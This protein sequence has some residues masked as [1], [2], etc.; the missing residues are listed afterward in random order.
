MG[1]GKTSIAKYLAEK[2]NLNYIDLDQKIEIKYNMKIS[3]I[4]KLK[5]ELEFRKIENK[6][7]ID[8][9]CSTKKF[10][11]SLGGGTPCYFNNMNLISKNS[12]FVFY[13]NTPNNILSQRL[14]KEKK[15]R[16][17]ISHFN[18]LN[19][20]KVFVSKHIFERSYFYNM[21]NYKIN[22]EEKKIEQIGNDIIEMI[23]L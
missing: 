10:I 1:C 4:F 21:A 3:E 14:Y 5:G 15:T 16:P 20:L 13:I 19:S 17:I 8:V 9:L 6:T 2:L 23:N 22:A 18:S 12:K 7:L 11:I